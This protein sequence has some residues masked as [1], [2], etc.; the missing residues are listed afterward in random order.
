MALCCITVVCSFYVPR[1]PQHDKF[2]CMR[3]YCDLICLFPLSAVAKAAQPH[4][5]TFWGHARTELG[6][7]GI[8]QWPEVKQGLGKLWK[9]TLYGKFLD[10]TVTEAT[11]NTLVVI[12]VACWFYVGEIIGR[13][14][15]IGYKV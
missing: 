2:L 3:K 15:I 6:P 14:S 13:R 9:S 5:S 11:K 1:V 12:E 4:L 10:V 7:P 8:S